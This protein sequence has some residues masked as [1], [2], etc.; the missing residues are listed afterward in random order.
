MTAE[1]HRSDGWTGVGEGW[2][3]TATMLAGILVWGGVGYLIDRLA[4]TPRVFTALGFVLGAA[5]ATTIVYLRYGKG[6]RGQ[7]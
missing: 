6:D 2:G 3:I 7:S 4:G 1:P 5:G